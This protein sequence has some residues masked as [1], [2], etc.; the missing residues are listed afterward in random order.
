[1][2]NSEEEFERAFEL[3]ATGVMTD[4]PTML[5][6]FLDKKQPHWRSVIIIFIFLFF[7][8]IFFFLLPD[9]VC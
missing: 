8:I 7:F 3:G 5:A 2:L 4:F 9:L 6:Q 1:V